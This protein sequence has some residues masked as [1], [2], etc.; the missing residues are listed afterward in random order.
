MVPVACGRWP[1]AGARVRGGGWWL[2][3]SA[4]WALGAARAVAGWVGLLG[5]HCGEG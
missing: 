1:V 2:L 3:R 4:R 5:T